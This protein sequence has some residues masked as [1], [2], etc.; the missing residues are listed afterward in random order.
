MLFYVN[1]YKKKK[2]VFKAFVEIKNYFKVYTLI[3]I[4]RNM[5]KFILREN[6][7]HLC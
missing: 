6:C 7:I 4:L 1:L 2:I 5:F 3:E